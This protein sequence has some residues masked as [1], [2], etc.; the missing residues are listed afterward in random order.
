MT[1]SVAWM[2]GI[3][4]ERRPAYRVNSQEGRWLWV[5][6]CFPSCDLF[7][8]IESTRNPCVGGMTGRS[9]Q[10]CGEVTALN[11]AAFDFSFAFFTLAPLDSIICCGPQFTPR[12]PAD[13]ALNRWAQNTQD[14][15]WARGGKVGKEY[16]NTCDAGEYRT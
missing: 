3:C 13:A 11:L 9:G 12:V 1:T 8:S 16:K 4:G 15:T 7:N 10:F 2:R 5:R 6:K 14:N